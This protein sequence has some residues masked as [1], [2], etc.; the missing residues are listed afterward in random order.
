MIRHGKP[1]ATD[2][3]ILAMLKEGVARYHVQKRLGC[4]FERVRRLCLKHGLS[5]GDNTTDFDNWTPPV[6][7]PLGAAL[8]R[9]GYV[10]GATA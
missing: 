3:E 8:E 6:G 7:D 4:S 2:E 1:I 5:L 10:R 9:A